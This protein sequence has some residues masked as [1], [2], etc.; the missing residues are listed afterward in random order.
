[1]A[2][3]NLTS[4]TTNGDPK[5]SSP[6]VPSDAAPTAG[7]GLSRRKLMQLAPTAAAVPLVG[8]LSAMPAAAA[9]TDRSA[10]NAVVDRLKCVQAEFAR[11]EPQYTAA[12]DAAEAACPR[13]GEFFS[14]FG[15]G[16][17]SDPVRDRERNERSAHEALYGERLQELLRSDSVRRYL[18]DEE[19]DLAKSDAKKIVDE[20][21]DHCARRD[22]AHELHNC[23]QW[24]ERFNAIFCKRWE[25]QRA[26][27]T[28]RAPDQE[29]VLA[30]LVLLADIME[31]E[32]DQERVVGIRDDMRRLMTA[33]H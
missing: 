10:W 23:D 18:T 7:E 30:K 8:F 9:H 15:L 16:R 4:S 27:L 14:R 21:D 25:A 13:K 20:F 26:F 3:T 11:I 32:Q 17:Y 29:A 1:M 22:E 5:A 6:S 2:A 24:E 28:T 31:G 12:F 33:I 19:V